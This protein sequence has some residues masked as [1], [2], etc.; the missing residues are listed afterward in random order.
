MVDA[1]EDTSFI[2]V[3]ELQSQGILASDVKKLTDGGIATAGAVLQTSVRRLL[4]I[5]GL[6]EA[7]VDK[8]RE[9]AKKLCA[10]SGQFR[11]AGEAL[12]KRSQVIKISTGSKELDS[13]LG[14]GV[15]T[16][17]ITEVFGEFRTGKTQLCHTLAV[18]TQ[19][20]R[21]AGGGEGTVLVV[22]TEGSFR[23]ERCA[24]IAE[25]RFDLDVHAV[26]DNIRIARAF[27]VDQQFD[28]NYAIAGMIAEDDAPCRLIIVDSVMNLFRTD[29]IGRGELAERQ[30]R[31]NQYLAQLK[32]IAEEYNVAVLLTNQ[33]TANPDSSMFSGDSKKPIGGHVLAHA[34]TTRLYLRKGK[35]EQRI[36]KLY[37]SPSLPEAEATF[38]LAEGGVVEAD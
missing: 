1:G 31:L 21:D 32:N 4:Q 27:T 30:Q 5:K 34:S 29:Y 36:A 11:S 33:V 26:L 22:D 24:E 15:E 37:D 12:A 35:A 28:L 25:K 18:T 13:L 6:S 3:Q 8:I 38:A 16:G 9:A 23:V 10:T 2:S 20:Q 14:G 19:L 17:S 7:K